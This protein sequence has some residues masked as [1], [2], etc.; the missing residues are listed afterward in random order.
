MTSVIDAQS[1]SCKEGF[2]LIYKALDDSP[3]CVKPTTAK[4]LFK[5]VG[6]NKTL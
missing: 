5:V 4:K 3:V 1:I 6:P 2:D